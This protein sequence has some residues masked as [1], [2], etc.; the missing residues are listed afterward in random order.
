MTT[1]APLVQL[2]LKGQNLFP[3]RDDV[4][5]DVIPVDHVAA[6]TLA[7]TAQAMCRRAGARVSALVRRL[8]SGHA[9]DVWSPCSVCTRR[10][11]FKD[12]SSGNELLN[13]IASRMEAQSVSPENFEKYS[14]PDAPQGDPEGHGHSGQGAAIET[15]AVEGPR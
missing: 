2:A 3:V 14:L 13:E 5:L 9:W 15:R 11:Y 10:K 4:I 7:V 6:A 8:E 1:T 12:K